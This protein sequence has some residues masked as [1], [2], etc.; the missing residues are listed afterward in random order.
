MWRLTRGHG[1]NL[2]KIPHVY[3]RGSYVYIITLMKKKNFVDAE[4]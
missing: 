1:L 3:V 2:T 4:T